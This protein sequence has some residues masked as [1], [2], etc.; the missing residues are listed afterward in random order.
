MD[1]EESNMFRTRIF[2]NVVA[3]TLAVLAGAIVKNVAWADS[4][5]GTGTREPAVIRADDPTARASAPAK[6]GAQIK[7]ERRELIKVERYVHRDKEGKAIPG[8]D[9]LGKQQPT[10]PNQPQSAAGEPNGN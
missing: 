1:T 7:P 8:I 5:G 4:Q 6:E 9:A 10:A 3:I 2:G